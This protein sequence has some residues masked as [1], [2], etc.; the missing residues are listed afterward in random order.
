MPSTIQEIVDL[1][2]VVVSFSSYEMRREYQVKILH[3][4]NQLLDELIEDTRKTNEKLQSL[5]D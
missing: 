1:V 3:K 5:L 2:D 4:I